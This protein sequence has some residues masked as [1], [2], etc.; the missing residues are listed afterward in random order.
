MMKKYDLFFETPN[1]CAQS[2]V[3][4]ATMKDAFA[5][6]ASHCKDRNFKIYYVNFYIEENDG[7]W[8][9]TFDV[10]SWS[11]FFRIYFPTEKAATAFLNTQR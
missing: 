1:D 3:R 10:G 9:L 8:V 7:L 6:M 5:A 4:V 2:V 11:D